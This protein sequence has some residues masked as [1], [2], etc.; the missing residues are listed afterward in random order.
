MSSRTAGLVGC[1]REPLAQ[2]LLAFLELRRFLV[3]GLA[4]LGDLGEVALSVQSSLVRAVVSLPLRFVLALTLRQRAT[5]IEEN[6]VRRPDVPIQRI[7]LFSREE[8]R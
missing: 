6:V 5:R 8:M 3:D 4:H 1:L 7:P 2:C